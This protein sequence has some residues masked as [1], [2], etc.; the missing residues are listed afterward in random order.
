MKKFPNV[1]RALFATLALSLFAIPT[2]SFA[3]TA[4]PCIA[5][6]TFDM[7]AT[8]TVNGQ[9]GWNAMGTYDQEIVSNTFGISTFGCKSLRISDATTS[10][11]YITN[12]I[13]SNFATNEAGET[14]ALGGT[15]NG[16]RNNRFEAQ[17]DLASVTQ[18]EQAGMHLSVSPDRGDGVRMSSL[19]FVDTNSGIEMYFTDV[20]EETSTT[21]TQTTATPI[22]TLTRTEPHTIKFLMD[23]VDGASNDIVQIFVDNNLTPVHTGRSWENFYRFSTDSF[24]QPPSNKS[25]TVN[26]LLFQAIDP[27]H[28]G[29]R[30]NGFLIDNVI[31]SS[32]STPVTGTT[33]PPASTT[34]PPVITLNGISPMNVFINSVFA[35]PGA[36]A[37]SGTTTVPVASST[38][39]NTSVLGNYVITYTATGTNNDVASTTRI[40]NVIATSTPPTIALNGSSTMNITINTA[41]TDLGA[42]SSDAVGTPIT[43]VATGTVNTT[44]LG[45]YTILYTATDVNN[46]V[47]T[48]TRTVN[49]V[50]APVVPPVAPPAN[51]GGG[52][53]GSYYPPVPGMPA[54]FV[55]APLPGQNFSVTTGSPSTGSPIVVGTVSTPTGQVLGVA[56]FNF[57]RSLRF[58]SR[59]DDVMEL[60]KMLIAG[61]DLVLA[62]PTKYFGRLTQ[63]ALM[64]WQKKNNIPST[65]FFGPISRAYIIR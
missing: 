44:A 2:G 14:D 64:K 65:G 31:L 9:G 57:S 11:P 29:N 61:G 36:T 38:N 60:Q 45:T 8:G 48:T 63:K 5:T 26:S 6:S 28:P 12:Q 34:T 15:P 25:R 27:A 4:P 33:T 16:T 35:D 47:A 22:A 49:V 7:F 46:N 20:I 56:A 52:G 24:P 1:S 30:F 17:F 19:G 40:V 3:Q 13:F 10:P 43:P 42:T 55:F 37:V 58:G 59:G 62:V 50:A 39:L 54:G 21:T 53:G 32:T 41:F 51:N 18:N 23:F